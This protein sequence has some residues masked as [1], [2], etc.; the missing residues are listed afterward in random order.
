MLFVW[1]V[2]K[3]SKKTHRM[4]NVELECCVGKDKFTKSIST[5]EIFLVNNVFGLRHLLRWTLKSHQAVGHSLLIENRHRT[6]M[7]IG[8]RGIP[9]MCLENAVNVDSQL[10]LTCC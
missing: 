2:R 1:M 4:A 5:R 3:V 10:R 9:S 7:F 6:F 8:C